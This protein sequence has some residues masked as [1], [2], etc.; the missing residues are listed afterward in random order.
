MEKYGFVYIWFDRKHKRYYIGCHWGTEDDG[1]ICSSPWM[2]RAHKRRPSDFKRRIL[3]RIY[4]TRKDMF[5]EESK[6]QALIKDHEL[7][8]RYYNIRRHG[9]NHW[10]TDEQKSLTI[11]QKLSAAQKR[12]FEDPEYKAKFMVTRKNLPPQTAETREKRRQSMLGKNVGRPKTEAFYKAMELKRGT[13]GSDYQKQRVKEI[14]TFKKLN[15]TKV[16]CIYCGVEGNIG[17]IARYHN[18][19][20]KQRVI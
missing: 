4:T 8:T 11:K 19:R 9:D 1:Y 13:K 15:S 18:N 14:G 5:V 16:H 20:C 12:N 17:T 10:T 7:K 2:K 3:S 6:W